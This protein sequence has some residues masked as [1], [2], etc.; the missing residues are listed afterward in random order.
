MAHFP[1]TTSWVT[2][3]K[4]IRKHHEDAENTYY[5]KFIRG[6]AVPT[7]HDVDEYTKVLAAMRAAAKQLNEDR[8]EMDQVAETFGGPSDMVIHGAATLLD[9]LKKKVAH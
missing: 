1:Q 6:D 7:Q 4:A 5:M 3:A 9:T 2:N 8:V